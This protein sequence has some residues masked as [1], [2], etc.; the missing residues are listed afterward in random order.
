MTPQNKTLKTLLQVDITNSARSTA[1]TNTYTIENVCF[2]Y[3]HANY[4]EWAHLS[5]DI[6]KLGAITHRFLWVNFPT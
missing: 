5:S 1:H 4:A 2:S 6:G 3:A